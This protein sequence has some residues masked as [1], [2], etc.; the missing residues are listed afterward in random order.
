[1]HFRNRSDMARYTFLFFLF[2]LEKSLWPVCGN[3]LE[4]AKSGGL[5]LPPEQLL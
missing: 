3:K 4:E 5:F 2:V 1:M